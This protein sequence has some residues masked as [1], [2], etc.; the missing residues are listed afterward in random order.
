[1]LDDEADWRHDGG[2]IRGAPP[3]PAEASS[4]IK[5]HD[6]E[7]GSQIQETEGKDRGTTASIKEKDGRCLQIM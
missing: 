1:M 6:F 7:K 4:L 2:E 5:K 3:L